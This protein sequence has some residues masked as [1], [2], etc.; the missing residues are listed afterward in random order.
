M[1]ETVPTYRTLQDSGDETAPPPAGYTAATARIIREAP[2]LS[3]AD[4]AAAVQR[5]AR[6]QGSAYHPTDAPLADIPALYATTVY[7]R[8]QAETAIRALDQAL[9]TLSTMEAERDAWQR[10]ATEGA[11]LMGRSAELSERIIMQV[12]GSRE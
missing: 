5:W 1:S 8:E 10:L 7:L 9:A 2:V 6:A 3:A 12:R 11:A 4:C